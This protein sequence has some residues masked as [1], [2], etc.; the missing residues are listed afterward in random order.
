MAVK[1]FFASVLTYAAIICSA[2][3]LEHVNKDE[4]PC[5]TDYIQ[6]CSSVYP[7]RNYSLKLSNSE[8]FPKEMIIGELYTCISNY[9]HCIPYKVDQRDLTVVLSCFAMICIAIIS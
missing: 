7:A 9:M 2:K 8:Y 3:P 4:A 1:I 5:N 6:K